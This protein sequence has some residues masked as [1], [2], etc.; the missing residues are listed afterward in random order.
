MRAVAALIISLALLVAACGGDDDA[1][2]TSTAPPATVTTTQASTTTPAPTTATATSTTT[3]APSPQIPDE[4]VDFETGSVT[5][6]GEPWLVAIADTRELRSRGL[7]FVTDLG[8]LDGM[9]FVYDTPTSG[10]FWMKNTL[11]P[12]D[13]AFF[14][15]DGTLVAV[16]Q[17]EPCGDQDPC[18]T[19]GPVDDY[20]YALEAPAGDLINLDPA[21]VLEGY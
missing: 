12:L 7:M 10:A 17:M 4:L 6:D 21:S 11:I 18:P 3:E 2:A 5:L 13:I 14:R 9:L 8:D 15:T 16:L 19:Y 20:Q 1:V